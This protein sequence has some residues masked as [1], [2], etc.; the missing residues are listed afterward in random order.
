MEEIVQILR[1]AMGVQ[2]RRNYDVRRSALAVIPRE[3]SGPSSGRGLY[4]DTT[5]KHVEP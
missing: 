2:A 4:V 1:Y 5:A 3:V